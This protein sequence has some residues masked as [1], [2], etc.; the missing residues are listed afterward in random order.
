[1]F[2]EGAAARQAS[3]GHGAPGVQ[4]EILPNLHAFHGASG[5]SLYEEKV[6]PKFNP[7]AYIDLLKEEPARVVITAVATEPSLVRYWLLSPTTG[8][9]FPQEVLVEPGSCGAK[10][11]LPS[12]SVGDMCVGSA[13]VIGQSVGLQSSDESRVYIFKGEKSKAEIVSG[14]QAGRAKL[15]AARPEGGRSTLDAVVH[16]EGAQRCPS[17]ATRDT[18][19]QG[20]GDRRS[21]A[22]NVC[23]GEWW[24][25]AVGEMSEV[26][27]VTT[28]G[29][30][31]F[32]ERAKDGSGYGIYGISPGIANVIV[33]FADDDAYPVSLRVTVRD[34]SAITPLLP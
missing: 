17:A 33:D 25:N 22:V 13:R 14:L 9:Y 12:R 32:A 7:Q 20:V 8:E 5:L 31:I 11:T 1:M 24:I 19:S 28:Q 29:T 27:A 23:A 26:A 10:T 15:A 30:R 21:F 2:A 3:Q 4:W 6:S 34:C 16:A 18:I